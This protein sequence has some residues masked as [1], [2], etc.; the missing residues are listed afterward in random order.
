MEAVSASFHRNVFLLNQLV[1]P[2]NDFKKVFREGMFDKPNMAGFIEVSHYLL[3][4]YDAERFKKLIEWPIICK[5]MEA[6]YRND[7]KDY[8]TLI[9]TE[10]P[11]MGFPNILVS[12]FHHASGPKFIIIM[13]KLSQLVLKRY[14]MKNSKYE[15]ISLPKPG[16]A[17]DLSRI[18]LEQ[19]KA[20][21]A[22]NIM[23]R[24]RNCIQMEKA[25]NFALE[26]QKEQ[27][28]KIKAELFNR[29]HS[30]EKCAA[31]APVASSLKQRL[32]SLEDSEI[33]Q[34]WKNSIDE[35]VCYIEKRNVLLKNLEK[36]CENVNDIISNLLSDIKALNG[37]QLEGVNCSRIS[38]MSFPPDVEHCLYHLY[39]DNKLVFCNF[40]LLL[41]LILY[42]V[43]QRLKKIGLKDLSQCLLQVEASVKDMKSMYDVFQ[44]FLTNIINST[45]KT[46]SV[47][48]DKNVEQMSKE[49]VLP[50]VKGVLFMPSPPIKIN[51]S[52][53]D[54]KNDSLK[55]LQITPEIAHKS[56]FSRYARHTQS[57]VPDLR[58]NLFVS[59]INIDNTVLLDINEKQG[60][61]RCFT[62]PKMN[63]LSVK[64]PTEKYSRLF[65]TFMNK[66]IKASSS[67]LSLPT[68]AQANSSAFTN[69]I[70][71]MSEFNITERRFFNLSLT[72]CTS[73]QF[74][75]IKQ[76]ISQNASQQEEEEERDKV[77][78]ELKVN[79]FELDE[80]TEVCLTNDVNK[81]VVLEHQNISK[82]RSI[83]DLVERYKKL[84][85]VS[86]LQ[87][88]HKTE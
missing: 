28:A 24:H 26:E 79:K 8:L 67:M 10:N 48:Y 45:K 51:T 55:L 78:C 50:F 3:T 19:A 47:L 73:E 56:L 4:V 25:V 39:N 29:K 57:H 31:E 64:K 65:S 5:K 34:M 17:N 84:L 63:R 37:K 38:D 53:A 75:P 22:D 82:R 87:N 21:I 80:F 44:M 30:I 58:T 15:V 16:F 23:S 85:E 41:T 86:N 32:I 33:I 74:S 9:A 69:T 2:S 6:K 71:K 60:L 49:D 11:N 83:S 14:I 20:N 62:T 72:T 54:A 81:G 66:N 42:Q 46:Q 59:R 27:M 7:V 1:P 43:Y 12:Y 88:E 36:A 70:K 77:E 18:Y 40:I 52:Y 13:W 35:N 61:N 76:N 68:T